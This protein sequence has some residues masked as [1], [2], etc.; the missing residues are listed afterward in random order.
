MLPKSEEL[1]FVDW[2]QI[3]LNRRGWR[4]SMLTEKGN[5]NSGL[6]SMIM[7]RERRPG[8]STLIKI[9]D[10]LGIPRMIVFEKYGYWSAPSDEKLKLLEEMQLIARDFSLAELREGTG[11]LSYV[12]DRRSRGNNSEHS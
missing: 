2:L 1:D 9:A 3:E 8:P 10:A 11:Y 4:Q 12:R 7:N 5:V 6:V